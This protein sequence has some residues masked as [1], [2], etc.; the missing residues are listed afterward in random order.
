MKN[1]IEHLEYVDMFSTQKST[2]LTNCPQQIIM[3]FS[4]NDKHELQ[5]DTIQSRYKLLESKTQRCPVVH[6][7]TIS[8]LLHLNQSCGG[9]PEEAF[10]ALLE[11]R[12]A[13]GCINLQW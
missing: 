6:K 3:A 8:T 12:D 1:I 5:R 7:K 10:A 2:W 9:I 4:V 13:E 11:R